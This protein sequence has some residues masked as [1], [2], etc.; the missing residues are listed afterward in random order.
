MATATVSW[1]APSNGGSPI[2]SVHDH[3]L[4]RLPPPRPPTTIMGSPPATTTTITG[5]TN[6]TS[7]TFTV[8]S[9]QRDRDRTSSTPSQ[10]G[11]ADR[12]D[13]PRAPTT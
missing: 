10:R 6:G 4:R 11:H 3:A 8:D 12:A 13:A 1:T 9:H 2:T 5:L 7:Y